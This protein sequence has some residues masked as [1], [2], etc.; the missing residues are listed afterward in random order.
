M[1]GKVLCRFAVVVNSVT[2]RADYSFKSG[3]ACQLL[4]AACPSM[5]GHCP[6]PSNRWAEGFTSRPDARHDIENAD[7]MQALSPSG[8]VVIVGVIIYLT[9]VINHQGAIPSSVLI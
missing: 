2:A 5:Y 7:E 4:G 1:T 9:Q 3:R 6:H 8:S